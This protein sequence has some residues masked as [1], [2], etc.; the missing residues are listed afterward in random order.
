MNP[1]VR[2]HL[3]DHLAKMCEAATQKPV[4][5]HRQRLL[6]A[7]SRVAKVETP[8]PKSASE[9]AKPKKPKKAKVDKE[10]EKAEVKTQKPK[11]KAKAK[12]TPKVSPA[13]P[14][15]M[16]SKAK[17]DYQNAKQSFLHS[18]LDTQYLLVDC[19]K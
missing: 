9:K 16:K 13:P 17:D 19:L 18:F 12:A 6:A 8:A 5:P 14:T 15:D 2:T 11:K 10:Q 1:N 3:P 4:N 7:S